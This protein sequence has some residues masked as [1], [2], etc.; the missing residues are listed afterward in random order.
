[1]KCAYEQSDFQGEIDSDVDLHNSVG[2]AAHNII[3]MHTLRACYKLL[4]E[5]IFFHK[6]M[7]LDLPGSREQILEQHIAIVDAILAGDPQRARHASEI[8]IDYVA[9]SVEQA[10]RTAERE[11][12]SHLRM[13]HRQ[14]GRSGR[15]R[16]GSMRG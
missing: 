2:E 1:M 12:V 4:A 6:R 15:N 16:K 11:T 7:I 3:L 14:V 10:R 8:H 13:Q 9:A 5:G